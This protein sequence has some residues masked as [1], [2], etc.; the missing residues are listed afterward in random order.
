M[1]QKQ[2]TYRGGP[3]RLAGEVGTKGR[4]K[5]HYGG[6]VSIGRYWLEQRLGRKLRPGERVLRGVLVNNLKTSLENLY[7]DRTPGTPTW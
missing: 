3:V 7:A 5:S 6:W 1:R 4:V 2:R